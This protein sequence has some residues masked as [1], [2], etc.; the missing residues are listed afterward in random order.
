MP[1]F[2]WGFSRSDR[3]LR[4]WDP[5]AG[6]TIA[7]M[8]VA[9]SLNDCAWSPVGNSLAAIGDAG[10]YLFTFK[11]RLSGFRLAG[12]EGRARDAAQFPAVT[13]IYGPSFTVTD[14]TGPPSCCW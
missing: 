6:G 1:A 8:R 3:S 12:T 9:R 7:V 14:L 13:L 2:G 11:A 5:T 10:L 4:V